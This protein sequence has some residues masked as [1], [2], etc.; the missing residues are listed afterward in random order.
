MDPRFDRRGFFRSEAHCGRVVGGLETSDASALRTAVEMGGMLQS[1]VYR[2]RYPEV[3]LSDLSNPPHAIALCGTETILEF[4]ERVRAAA[5][6]LPKELGVTPITG[7]GLYTEYAICGPSKPMLQQIRMRLFAQVFQ[8]MRLW[9]DTTWRPFEARALHETRRIDQLTQSQLAFYRGVAERYADTIASGFRQQ[10]E[11][12]QLGTFYQSHFVWQQIQKLGTHKL[13]VLCA[14][15]KL[16]L[17]Y[18]NCTGDS[19]VHFLEF[20]RQNDPFQ[21]YRLTPPPEL[22]PEQPDDDT[23]VVI[24]KAYTSGT[25]NL[26]ADRLRQKY[27]N[28]I[29]V[30]RVA[31]FPKSYTA[32]QQSDYIV[33]AGRLYNSGRVLKAVNPHRWH[34]DLFD[35]EPENG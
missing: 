19:R 20:H 9:S 1:L 2:V 25:I 4:H 22:L 32:I 14:G 34:L 24:D 11:I 23:W 6:R 35:L 8:E 31:L 33:Y 26:A 12:L 5:E 17:G 13:F 29:R 15:L 10:V 28:R 16:A 18:L 7:E 30:V 27:G 21:L 3:M